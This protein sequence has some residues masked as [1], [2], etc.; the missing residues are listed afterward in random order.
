MPSPRPTLPDAALTW[1]TGTEPVRVVTL[2]CPRA[3]IHELVA[4]G[5]GIA[6]VEAEWIRAK[7][8]SSFYPGSDQVVT[9]VAEPEALPLTPCS[10]QV[11][12][13]GSG[14]DTSTSPAQAQISRALQAGGWA[15]GWQIIRDDSVPWVQRLMA[16]LRSVN[17]DVM[18][19]ATLVPEALVDSKYFPRVETRDFRM[20]VPIT[21]A[22]VRE[23]V[24]QSPAVAGLDETGRAE[25]LAR[26]ETVFDGVG[27]TSQ[28]QL[29]YQL[30]CW[31]AHVDHQE[32]TVPITF[33]D[34]ALHI[35]I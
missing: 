2:A 35:A 22:R 27:R 13:V 17:D 19:S 10:A 4:R 7:K 21:R 20:W 15:A 6:A 23:M 9:M 28:M 26:A 18:S 14:F 8:L 16:V 11:A 33:S 1:L 32:L 24:A 29:P 25:V 3:I 34:G 30:H 5:H 31:R 12:L